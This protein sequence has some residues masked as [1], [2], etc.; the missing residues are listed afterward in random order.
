MGNTRVTSSIWSS[1]SE[2]YE[3]LQKI[4]K[5]KLNWGEFVN[6]YHGIGAATDDKCNI[7]IIWLLIIA[8]YFTHLFTIIALNQAF[9]SK[10][11]HRLKEIGYY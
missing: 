1:F 3:N 11:V 4:L 7:I 10:H 5:L 6:Q 9:L 2:Y 8:E